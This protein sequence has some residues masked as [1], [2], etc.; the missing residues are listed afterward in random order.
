MRSRC[1]SAPKMDTVYTARVKDGRYSNQSPQKHYYGKTAPRFGH[2]NHNYFFKYIHSDSVP[3]IVQRRQSRPRKWLS[4]R[5]SRSLRERLAW[6]RNSLRSRDRARSTYKIQRTLSP[7][8]SRPSMDVSS[9]SQLKEY[10]TL[11]GR[12]QYNS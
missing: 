4:M 3:K 6:N 7:T 10:T 1:N 8:S 11:K 5:Y 12:N 2:S 9:N